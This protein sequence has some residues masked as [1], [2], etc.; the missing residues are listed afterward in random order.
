MKNPTKEA[1]LE[2]YKNLEDVLTNNGFS[3]Q[4]GGKG[5]V[6]QYED[7]LPAESDVRRA[8]QQ[9]R[10]IRN[11]YQHENRVL[12]LPANAAIKFLNDLIKQL[13]NRKCAKDIMTRPKK[14]VLSDK[15]VTPGALTNVITKGH[16][17]P[18]ISDTGEYLGAVDEH[19]LLLMYTQAKNVQLKTF[20]SNTEIKM[21]VEKAA[22]IINLDV[23]VSELEPDTVYAV[24]DKK[25]KYRGMI[26]RW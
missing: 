22:K 24:I 1:F 13:D 11:G 16:V 15:P 9:C 8:L 26:A 17:I 10:M 3:W 4:S 12:F 6:A 2:V 25:N 14:F 21:A 18:I 20:L 19:V 23:L 5:S 7:T